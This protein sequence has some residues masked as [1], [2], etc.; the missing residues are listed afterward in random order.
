VTEPL[1]ERER[2]VLRQFSGMLNAAEVAD[3][4]CISGSHLKML[5]A[6]AMTSPRMTREAVACR[7]MAA[8][9]HRARGITSVGL[10][11]VALV[12]PVGLV[13]EPDRRS[14]RPAR[15]LGWSGRVWMAGSAMLPAQSCW[16]LGRVVVDV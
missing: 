9:A 8:L 6:R 3:E 10:N 13:S 4:L 15:H 11:A 2:D 14:S 1:T 7:V 16:S 12:K 5:T